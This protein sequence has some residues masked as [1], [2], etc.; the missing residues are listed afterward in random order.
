MTS[1]EMRVEFDSRDFDRAI[2][3]LRKLTQDWTP[4]MSAIGTSLVSTTQRRFNEGRDPQG[5]FWKPLNP[6]YARVKQGP[7]TLVG[8]GLEGGLQGSITF[9]PSSRDVTV[10]TPKVYGA[11]HQFGATIK[12][13]NGKVLVFR[14][15]QGV[16]FA[17]KV[18]VPARPFLG[19][20]EADRRATLHAVDLFFTE[21]L[22]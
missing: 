17:R 9:V 21:L 1:V 4:L 3:K 7:R 15:A 10:G 2:G 5:N 18:T 12:P 20:G 11:V 22:R 8:L 14:M 6:S 16:T 13:K 19:F